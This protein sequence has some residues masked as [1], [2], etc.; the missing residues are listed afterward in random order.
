VRWRFGLRDGECGGGQEKD[1]EKR[2]AG[3]HLAIVRAR[4]ELHKDGL[5]FI[6]IVDLFN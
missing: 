2:A 4:T 5:V 6:S 1:S 3:I